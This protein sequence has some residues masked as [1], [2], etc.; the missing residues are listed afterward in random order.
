MIVNGSGISFTE[1]DIGSEFVPPIPE[2]PRPKIVALCEHCTNRL[3]GRKELKPFEYWAF[4]EVTT[5]EMAD[6]LL[7]MK[8]RRPYTLADAVKATGL[9]AEPLEK[10]LDEMS[11]IGLLE[12]N[13]EN[14]TRTKQWVLP[15][16]V[17]GS[18][19]FL[20]MRQSQ[21]DEHPAV[22]KF[23]E[24]ASKGALAKATPMVPPG[25]AGIGMHV[26]PVEQAIQ[27]EDR[28]VSIEHIEHWLDKYEGK[29]AASPC[30]CRMSRA[31]LGEGCGDDPN[32]WCIAVGDM[33]DYVVETD[34]GHYITREEVYETLRQ[35]EA[36]GFVHQITNI[37]GEDKIFAIC[38]CNV[39]VCYA[40]RTSQLFN[41]PNLSRSAYVA[42]TETDKCV[43]CGRCVEVCPA[44]AVK[45]GQKLCASSMGEVPEYPKQELPDTVK[46]G[47]EKWSP[48]YR[49]KNRIETYDAGT[50]PCKT[51]CPA[52]IAVQGYLKL[53]AQGRYRDAL[54][55]IK[56][57]NPL[58]AICGRIC[59]RRC[60]DACTRGRIDSAVAIDEVKK[61]IA[62][63]D[64]A[65]EHRYV[66]EVVTPTRAGGF[67]DKIAVIGA[68]PAGLSCAFYLAEKGYKPVVFEKNARPGGMLTYGIPSYKL[69]KDVIEAE[70]DIIRE[71]GVDIRL[72]VEV[73]RDVTL[74]ELRE[75]G[76]K[77]F[78]VAIG[79]QGG[80][81]PGIPGEGAE[82]V[83][84][85]VDFLR[86]VAEQQDDGGKA[87]PM[88]GRTIVVGGGNVAID[89]ARTAA[90]LG[91]E[92]VEMFC[93]ESSEDMP[94]STEEVVEANE[95]GVHI[96][97]GWGPVEVRTGENGRVSEVVFK[98]CLRVFNDEGRFDPQYDENELRT[99][100]ADRVVFSIGQ[101]IVWGDLLEGEAV[102]L[103]RGQGAVADPKTYQTA[104]PDIFVGGDV[105]TGPKFAID[106][107][108]AGHEAAVSI[109]RFVQDATL[110]IGRNPR[111]YRELN[112][113]D[114]DFGSY[115][116][117]SRGDAVHDYEREKAEPFREYVKTFTEEQVRAETARCL[118]CGASVVDENKCIGCG[119]CT[120]KCAF[121]AI[122]LHRE[123]P[124]CSNMVK[125]EKKVPSLAKYA[126]KREIKIRFGKK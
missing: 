87:E 35:A 42:R 77:A 5:D 126:L 44:G 30:S 74:D 60:E 105:Y 47:P 59:N 27:M 7:K 108:A 73:G 11:Y 53:A 94:A 106:A 67:D 21:I 92:H 9:E 32:D 24:Q 69:E 90:R 45:L 64:L 121:D 15:M 25:G 99:V 93:L 29:Y 110:T 33:A 20:N 37:D 22:A 1:P 49:N 118:G 79:C 3:L 83:S 34:R 114:V 12:Y 56:R 8:M 86:G 116:T 6:V 57:E 63:Q 84:V 91:S 17:P 82:G 78:Y 113:D 119:L 98:R 75:Q 101:S 16:L 115:D 85:A 109:H 100:A 62:E 51:A 65:A 122:H 81:L 19:E 88:C 103:G 107:I 43:A 39:N 124:E 55:L 52:H 61:F 96:S 102:E 97:C 41:T 125:Y 117:A 28:S 14:P 36:N 71:M 95:D 58:P 48:D 123:H 68:G 112:K 89:V 66:P 80:R 104:Q 72:G 46:W 70:V 26:I 2:N 13:W 76:F 40:L 120:T 54:A 50:A 111:S 31:K 4:A 18:A 38:N 10:L 23:F